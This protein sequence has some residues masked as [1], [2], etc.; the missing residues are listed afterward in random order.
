MSR[1]RRS[2]FSITAALH[3]GE[4]VTRTERRRL[5]RYE[6]QLLRCINVFSR[7]LF[8]AT[9]GQFRL[10]GR[11]LDDYVREVKHR[12]KRKDRDALY[13]DIRGLLLILRLGTRSHAQLLG[14]NRALQRRQRRGGVE[15][16]T[17]ARKAAESFRNAI[18]AWRDASP[19]RTVTA[20]VIH[21]LH[22]EDGNWDLGL[23][24]H[25]RQRLI[26]NAV[27]RYHRAREKT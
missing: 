2:L 5:A 23:S 7:G 16:G 14:Q 22:R 25:D 1:R 26:D 24:P 11:E 21:Y 6:R 20:G 15:R 8:T 19:K 9:Y 17:K 13:H 10:N 3:A 12:L 18:D 4:Q 27:R